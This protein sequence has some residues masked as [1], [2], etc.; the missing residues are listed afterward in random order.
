MWSFAIHLLAWQAQRRPTFSFSHLIQFLIKYFSCNTN[1]N[2]VPRAF[3]LSWGGALGTRLIPI[4]QVLSK[5]IFTVIVYNSKTNGRLA[6]VNRHDRTSANFV[7][8]VML[9]WRLTVRILKYWNTGIS[10]SLN[11]TPFLL[12]D[13]SR[14]GERLDFLGKVGGEHS[15]VLLRHVSWARRSCLSSVNLAIILSIMAFTIQL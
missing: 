6:T 13:M 4:F 8:S 2:L 7:P 9:Y 10:D 12:T 3:S 11:G 5:I 15:F 14:S 1:I